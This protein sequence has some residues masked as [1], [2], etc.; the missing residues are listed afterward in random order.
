MNKTIIALLTLTAA[1]T[2]TAGDTY[3]R[4]GNIYNNE[5][6][7]MVEAG[8]VQASDLFKDQKHNTAPVLNGGYHGEDFNADL[9]GINYRFLGDND[10]LLNMSAYVVGSGVPRDSDVA[11]SLKGT[12]RRDIAIDLGLNADFRLDPNN[13]ISTYL[14][15]DV[16]GAY[17]GF[18]GGATYFHIMN[19]GNVDF[20][21]FASVSYQNKDY[22]DYYFGVTDKEARANRKAYTGDA[23]VNYGLGYKLVVPITEHWQ[24]SQV[25]QYTRL[26]SGIS[27]SSIVDSANQWAVGATVSYNF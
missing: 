11:K 2:A 25:S 14:Q 8:V 16:S 27:D 4:N 10:E 12:K 15:H 6:G 21:P 24:I 1:G 5:G 18:Q 7:W 20:V 22:V 3:I 23:T 19:I 26:G 17:K 13:V 9:G